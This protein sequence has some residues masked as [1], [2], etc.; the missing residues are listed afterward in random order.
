MDGKY[1]RIVPPPESGAFYYNYK[2]WGVDKIF[3]S[4]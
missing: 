4:V 2:N 1:I 3:K